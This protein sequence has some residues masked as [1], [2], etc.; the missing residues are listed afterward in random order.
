MEPK[1]KLF[2][3][4]SFKNI[5]MHKVRSSSTN[6]Y[7]NNRIN[8][9]FNNKSQINNGG[10][11]LKHLNKSFIDPNYNKDRFK[12]KYYKNTGKTEDYQRLAKKYY[13]II[14]S[15]QDELTKQ[16]IKNYN[17][18]EQ[19]FDLK[20]KFNELILKKKEDL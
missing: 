20:Q 14:I 12:L 2:A 17:L 7:D 4:N 18:L 13:S 10:V 8:K 1:N 5:P 15:L 16:T 19:N 11:G 3:Q 9:S 6:Q